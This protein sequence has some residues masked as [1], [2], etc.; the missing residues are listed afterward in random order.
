MSVIEGDDSPWSYFGASIL[1]REL[2][3]LGAAWHS[4]GWRTH[5]ILY[6]PPEESPCMFRNLSSADIDSNDSHSDPDRSEMPDLKRVQW[7]APTP[8][9]WR[10]A[11]VKKN[12]IC[13]VRFY[14]YTGYI[15]EGGSGIIRHTDVYPPEGYDFV[16]KRELIARFEEGYIF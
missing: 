11:F 4:L 1:K 14:T 3:Q 8:E 9:E 7:I 13:I 16:T 12:D 15:G 5:T 10:P 2:N 6:A